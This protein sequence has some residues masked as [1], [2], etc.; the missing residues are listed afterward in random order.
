[1]KIPKAFLCLVIG[2]ATLAWLPDIATGQNV[3]PESGASHEQ[4]P[5][6]AQMPKNPRPADTATATNIT[7]R[8]QRYF[9]DLARANAAEILAARLADAKALA[10]EVRNFARQ[11]LD[12]HMVTLD[13]LK[14]LAQKKQVVLP[15]EPNADQQKTLEKLQRITSR[16][17]DAFYVEQAGIK[18]HEQTLDLLQ[19]IQ[20]SGHDADLKTMAEALQPMVQA[21]LQ[22]AKKLSARDGH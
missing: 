18:A 6:M 9:Q 4:R 12:E 17:F 21:H 11:M 1:M 22:T 19:K 5:E 14:L 2:V 8:D 16:D 13:Q 15:H 7:R 3:Q 10:P 20:R